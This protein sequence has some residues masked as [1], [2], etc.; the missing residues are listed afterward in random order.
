MYVLPFPCSQHPATPSPYEKVYFQSGQAFTYTA[1][2]KNGSA[3]GSGSGTRPLVYSALG[4]HANY[5]V[6]GT[7]SRTI[8]TLVV[9]D[10]TSA[11]PLWDPILSAYYY[12]YT[13]ASSG[14][15]NGTFT[16][17]PP[18][19]PTS[20]LTFLGR[21][22]DARYPASDPRQSNF[23]NLNVA[24][25]YES[26]PTGPLDKGLDRAD[27]CPDSAKGCT[28]LSVLPAVSGESGT[29]TVSRASGATGTGSL[30]GGPMTATAS[31]SGSGSGSVMA[32][33][34]RVASAGPRN[35]GGGWVLVGGALGGGLMAVGIAV[36]L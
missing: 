3:S 5:A 7:H 20:W 10:T 8:A 18:A 19:I 28:T 9:N 11:G 13:P 12:T 29:V 31:G 24:W 27:V 1:L 34:T 2:T 35:V 30:V 16:P 4:S 32:S 26:G 36:M 14:L 25:K 17:V 21:W 33:T 15:T 22:G 23:L 6:P